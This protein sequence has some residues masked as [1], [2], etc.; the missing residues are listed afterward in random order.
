VMFRARLRGRRT[1]KMDVKES[2]TIELYR[3]HEMRQEDN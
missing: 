2:K 1:R 3:D